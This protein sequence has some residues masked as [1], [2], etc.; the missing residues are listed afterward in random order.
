MKKQ[1][2]IICFLLCLSISLHA[3]DAKEIIRKSNDLL[4]GKTSKVTMTMNIVRPEWKRSMTMKSWSKGT[5]YFL[6]LVTAPAKDRGTSSLK[7]G[8]ELW[9]WMPSIERTIKVSPSMMSQSWMGS[10]FT[11]DDL[12]N[13]SSIVDDYTHDIVAEEKVNGYDCWKIQLTPKEDAAVVWSKVF[14]WISK[15]GY[16]QLKSENYDEDDYLVN[17]MNAYDIKQLGDRKIPSR[18]EM[19]PADEE[20]NKTVLIYQ[21]AEFD[22]PIPDSFFSMQNM[23]RVR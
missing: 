6:V 19:I 15:E 13:A 3:Q 17:T 22:T 5:E 16:W 20:G 21:E 1:S 10:D 18:M 23:K 7:R 8:N 12:L 9:N 2:L 14:M 11:N 4:N